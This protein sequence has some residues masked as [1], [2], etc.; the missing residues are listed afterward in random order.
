MQAP[1]TKTPLVIPSTRDVD[2][3]AM[4]ISPLRRYL[5]K[6]K[7]LDANQLAKA[8]TID[9]MAFLR[10]M[11]NSNRDNYEKKNPS[12]KSSLKSDEQECG[13][14]RTEPHNLHL[15]LS[16]VLIQEGDYIKEFKLSSLVK[17]VEETKTKVTEAEV[18]VTEVSKTSEPP[19]DS[20]DTKETKETKEPSKE[21][22]KP[23]HPVS[24]QP[25]EKPVTHYMGHDHL[26]NI[27]EYPLK[28]PAPKSDE[29]KEK[30]AKEGEK[31]TVQASESS[32]PTKPVVQVPIEEKGKPTNLNSEDTEI[33]SPSE[34][35]RSA[36]DKN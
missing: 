27:V 21:I 19:K 20:K 28:K 7:T 6:A 9:P 13:H 18:Q 32:K 31:S 14:C 17:P 23:Q 16:P 10:G 12:R 36:G 15:K 8:K 3:D 26:G 4:E 24:T 5:V 35:R 1:V 34:L 29:K 25:P 30:E 2:L 22:H 33:K 11:V